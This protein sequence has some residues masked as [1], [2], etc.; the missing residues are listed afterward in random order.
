MCCLVAS[1]D[2]VVPATWEGDIEF[3]FQLK[4]LRPT[5]QYAL[6]L[7]FRCGFGKAT[8]SPTMWVAG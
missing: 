7:T 8:E 6:W 2:D 1:A 3:L 5:T 4:A